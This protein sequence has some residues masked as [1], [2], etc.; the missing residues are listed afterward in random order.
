LEE[1]N[2]KTYTK[3][4]LRASLGEIRDRGWIPNARPGNQ[5]GVGNTLEDLLGIKEN[6][7]PLSNAAEW[8]LKAQSGPET[9]LT[10][11]FHM[12]PSPRTMRLV[13]KLLL[14]SYG[15]AHQQA[16]LR[17]PASERSFRQTISARGCSDRGF[18]VVLDT[19][20]RRVCV[21]F[22]ATCVSTVHAGWL[23]DVEAKVGNLRELNPQPYWG[24]DDLGHKAGTKLTNC[25]YAIADEKSEAGVKFFWYRRLFM[26]SAFS[27]NKFIAALG[28]G[29]ILVDFDARTKH[30]HGT[31]FR[32]RAGYLPSL[33]DSADEF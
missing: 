31:K 22:D 27:M 23:A 18:R 29:D 9:S 17:F 1:S 25:F 19:V 3:E 12:E 10:T 21:A 15:W 5:G 33:Y 6:N 13:P 20:Q 30:N 14:P 28:S 26:L 32:A 11:L 8:E 2:M 4:S 16:G 24:Y 7:L